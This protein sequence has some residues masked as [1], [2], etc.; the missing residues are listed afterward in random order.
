MGY[1][2]NMD[3]SP[4]LSQLKD[5]HLPQA[6][7]IFPLA[8][9]WYILTSLIIAAIVFGLWWKFVKNKYKKQKLEAY[10]L[11]AEI[12]R[13]QSK[14]M[15]CEVSILI[16]R[17]AILKFPEEQVHTLFGEEWLKFLDK[18]GK[19]TNFTHGEGRCLL[20]IYQSSKIE[21]PVEFFLVVKQWLG[22]VL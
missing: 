15:L 6:I 20:N 19:T 18:T 11:L 12:E 8:G 10:S 5:V 3:T 21:N 1:L 14:E 13:N 4:D 2:K 17:V 9:G 16:K 7:S 22:E